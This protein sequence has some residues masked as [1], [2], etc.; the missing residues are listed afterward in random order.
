M[1]HSKTIDSPLNIGFV[2][3]DRI[4]KPD[5]VQQYVKLLGNWLTEQG[6]SVCYLV[7]YSPQAS[8][9]QVYG[10]SRTFRVRFNK[11]RMAIPLPA[12]TRGIKKVLAEHQFD[13]LHVQMPHS[14][15]LAGRV[16]NAADDHTA[17]VG[18]FHVLPHGALPAV[19]TRALGLVLRRSNRRFDGF[20]SVSEAARS[21]AKSHF[22]IKSTVL[23]NVVDLK[24]FS[25]G[26]PI[27]SLAG[28]QNIVFLG[29]LVERKGARHLLQAYFLLLRN[30]P[31]LCKSTRLVLCGDGP[32]RRHLEKVAKRIRETVE[33]DI[34]FTGFL[35]EAEK[36]NYLASAD[37]AVFPSTGGESFGIVLIEAMAAGSGV[38]IGGNNPGYLTVL[39]DVDHT[40]FDPKDT[41][42]FADLMKLLL[43][44]KAL[45]KH[46]HDKQQELVRQYDIEVVGTK[47]VTFYRKMLA[48]RRKKI[49]NKVHV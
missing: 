13:V 5:G 4:D 43:T 46:I 39:E 16:V 15:L 28:K 37:V 23:P 38:V 24:A 10:L 29:R 18:T 6:H 17:V 49:N 27:A 35:A 12:P 42:E 40:T 8:E 25:H 32:D 36:A 31:H 3:D 9:H 26:R 47:L 14:P 41:D 22:M 44:D 45:V 7:G 30:S 2:L 33:A 48:A 21:F 34:Y 11:N 1:P 19:A 20:L